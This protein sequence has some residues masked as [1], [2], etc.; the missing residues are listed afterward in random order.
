M[1]GWIDRVAAAFG[2][3]PLAP[4]Q[5]DELLRA[6][7]DVAHGVERRLTPVATFLAGM[8]AGRARAAGATSGHAIGDALETLRSLLPEPEQEPSPSG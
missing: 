5:V 3:E 7:R 1:E 6:A 8:G 2:E 4:E